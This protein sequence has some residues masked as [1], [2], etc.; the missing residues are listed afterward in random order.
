M[1]EVSLPRDVFLQGSKKEVTYIR[2]RTA[3]I[4]GLLSIKKPPPFESG[5][6]S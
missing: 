2:N 4:S 3:A 1:I 5:L 6:S